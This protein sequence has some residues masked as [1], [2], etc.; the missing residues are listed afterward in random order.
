MLAL[1]ADLAFGPYYGLDYAAAATAIGGMY[2][3]G[4]RNRLG[5][6]LYAVSSLAMIAFALLAASPPILIA[7]AIAFGMAVRA[8][9]RWST[10]G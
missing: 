4:N 6:A 9:W 7:N 5:L 10:E 1:P 8:F 2:Y 3:V